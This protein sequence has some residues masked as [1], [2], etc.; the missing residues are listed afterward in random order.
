MTAEAIMG[1]LNCY[2]QAVAKLIS[3]ETRV[4]EKNYTNHITFVESSGCK[5]N[6]RK[7]Y[8]S[9]RV[10]HLAREFREMK[11]GMH[12]VYLRISYECSLEGYIPK[13]L[14]EAVGQ[15]AGMTPRLR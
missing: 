4:K 14:Q 9:N 3:Q 1:V 7:C 13:P 2:E 5:Q 15:R 12:K 6:K 8:L 11:G 10:G